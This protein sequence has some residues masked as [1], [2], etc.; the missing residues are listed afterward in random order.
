[1]VNLNRMK[2]KLFLEDE[3]KKNHSKLRPS[4]SLLDVDFCVRGSLPLQLGA[5]VE[6][7]RG[8]VERVVLGGL[9]P[10]EPGKSEL[11]SEHF[12]VVAD[13]R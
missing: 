11:S 3:N 7:W 9:G 6:L 8:A 12:E 5:G 1:M 13:R 10:L 2:K 4:L